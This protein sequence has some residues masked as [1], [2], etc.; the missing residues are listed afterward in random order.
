MPTHVPAPNHAVPVKWVG[1]GGVVVAT[2]TTGVARRA[3]R[4]IAYGEWRRREVLLTQAAQT[5]VRFFVRKSRHGQHR[6]EA[7]SHDHGTR[8]H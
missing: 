6:W 8:S 4:G 3:S 5:C 1:D 7:S 2:A